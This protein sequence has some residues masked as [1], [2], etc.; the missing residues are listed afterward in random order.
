MAL[1]A[2]AV[3]QLAEWCAGS[4]VLAGI[5]PKA[6]NEY[7]GYDEPGDVKYL[8][9]AEDVNSRERRFLGWFAFGF[10]LPDGKHPAELAAAALL[11]VDELAATV[12]SIQ[13]SRYVLAMVVLVN[14]GVGMVLRLEDEE[15]EISGRQLSRVFQKGE[16]ICAHIIP[17]GRGKWLPGPGWLQWPMLLMPGMQDRL[18]KFQPSP[19]DVE[20]LLQQRRTEPSD[21]SRKV[22]Y[23]RDATL[24]AAV[25]RMT[26]AARSKGRRGLIMSPEEWRKLVL[27]YMTTGKVAEFYKAIVR[28]AGEV[29]SAEYAN[30][31]LALAMNIWNSTP[32]P[33]RRGRSAYEIGWPGEER[34]G[35]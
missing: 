22:E 17:V 8:P 31:W 10:K 24:D 34:L 5:R 12:K 15:F 11:N 33:D 23:P 27:S 14:P 35:A 7:F 21:V 26:E 29:E 28:R 30:T 32:Q 9:G 1:T 20:R 18:K 3:E 4:D 25:A 2:T 19:V 13:G 16:S 6:R